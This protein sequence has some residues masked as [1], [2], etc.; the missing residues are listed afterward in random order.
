M[1]L[2]NIK[3]HKIRQEICDVCVLDDI[4]ECASDPCQNAGTCVNGVNRFW[5]VC[6]DGFTGSECEGI[7][8]LFMHVIIICFKKKYN[9]LVLFS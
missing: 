4:D 8:R 1:S 3:K 5:C 2:Y 7:S 6:V 9:T